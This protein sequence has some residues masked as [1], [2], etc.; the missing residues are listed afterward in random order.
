MLLNI[1]KVKNTCK[2]SQ[3][4]I[5]IKKIYKYPYNKYPYEYRTYIY[6][7]NT[8]PDDYYRQLHPH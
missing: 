3:I 4:F 6:P 7:M 8:I 1:K 5:N 2:Y